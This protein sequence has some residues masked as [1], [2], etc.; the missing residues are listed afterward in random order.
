MSSQQPQPITCE[1]LRSLKKK[2]DAQQVTSLVNKILEIIYGNV[3]MHATKSD[4]TFYRHPIPNSILDTIHKSLPVTFA[5]IYQTNLDDILQGLQT[6]FPDS[7]I[8]K[9]ILT[10]GSDGKFIDITDIPE[11]INSEVFKTIHSQRYI[12]I[13][14]S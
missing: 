8:S 7:T 9:K 11:I 3:I 5:T 4:E 2:A 10:R 13:D 14:W 1:T 6:L 12:V